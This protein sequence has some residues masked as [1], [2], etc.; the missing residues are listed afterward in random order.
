MS[1]LCSVC[2][3]AET[4][5]FFQDGSAVYWRCPV[6]EATCLDAAHL[7]APDAEY[8]RYL[9]HDNTPQDTG[10]RRFLEKLAMPLIDRLPPGQQGLDYG[11]G[12]GPVLAMLLREAGHGVRI[13]DPFFAPEP[14]VLHDAYDFITCS[15]VVEHFHQPYDEFAFL[16]ELLNPGGILGIMTRFQTEDER[17]A[18]WSYRRDPT[19]VTFYKEATF[20]VLAELFGWTCEI[21]RKDVVFL[22]KKRTGQRARDET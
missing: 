13:F 10:Y 14:E 12:P 21:P 17:F 3:Q 1:P 20:H 5:F 18:N 6:C 2:Q 22:Y 15:E 7:P 16:N 11:C 4:R 9:E 19:H 8:A